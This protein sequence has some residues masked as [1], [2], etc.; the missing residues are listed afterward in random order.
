MTRPSRPV[1]LP[2]GLIFL[3]SLWLIGSWLVA[4][5]PG[6]PIQTDSASYTP[7]IRMMLLSVTIGLMIGWPLLRLSQRP[8]AAP[9]RLTVLD[10]IVL[11]ALLQVVLWPLRLVTPWTATRTAAI[12]ATLGTWTIL[13]G[14]VVASASGSQ[15]SGPRLLAMLAC[16]GMCLAGPA[17]AWVG[18]MAG[19]DAI[20]MIHLSP[21]IALRALGS[22]GGAPVSTEQ[23]VSLS[24]IGVAGAAVWTALGL[25]EHLKPTEAPTGN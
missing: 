22:E 21:I 12:D 6:R 20:D 17:L 18:V 1:E 25:W 3:A 8:A 5:G 13:A 15:R 2:R 10:L 24:V 19:V 23:W 7:G 4:I 14:A 16:L 9:F 11:L